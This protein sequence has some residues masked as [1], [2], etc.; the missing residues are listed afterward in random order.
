MNFVGPAGGRERDDVRKG[1]KARSRGGNLT[2][3]VTRS[4]CERQKAVAGRVASDSSKRL[5]SIP[6]VKIQGLSGINKRKKKR[7]KENIV[8]SKS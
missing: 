7:N 1:K 8:Q 3:R 4:W 6:V 2:Y 5:K